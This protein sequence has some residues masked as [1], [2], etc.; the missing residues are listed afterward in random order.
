MSHFS[1]ILSLPGLPKDPEKTGLL[2]HT[3]S[4][5]LNE[6][7]PSGEYPTYQTLN[8]KRRFSKDDLDCVP[9][10]LC[11]DSVSVRTLPQSQG[12]RV[13]GT[14]RK[15]P[16]PP[17]Q[18]LHNGQYMCVH[19]SLR[20]TCLDWL[21][22]GSCWF[23]VRPW[24]Y[25]VGGYFRWMWELQFVVRFYCSVGNCEARTMPFHHGS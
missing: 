18:I 9:L 23:I 24:K 12:C 7:T 3:A 5:S 1:L 16:P 4:N 20:K 22:R 6:L 13:P 11:W 17:K 14:K 19:Q 10:T 8:G 25:H 2:S 15:I 21:H